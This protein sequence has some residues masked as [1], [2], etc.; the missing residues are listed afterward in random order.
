MSDSATADM[1][2]PKDLLGPHS[3]HTLAWQHLFVP[4]ELAHHSRARPA[5]AVRPALQ[6]KASSGF[7]R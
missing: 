7:V 1:P 3:R 5:L 6:T 2:E 4:Q